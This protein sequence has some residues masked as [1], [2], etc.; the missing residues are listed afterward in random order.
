MTVP[1]LRYLAVTKSE[2]NRSNKRKITVSVKE[3]NG[4]PAREAEVNL[5]EV[6]ENEKLKT[7]AIGYTNREGE[8]SFNGLAKHKSYVLKINYRGI[9]TEKIISEEIESVVED[10]DEYEQYTQEEEE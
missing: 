7:L 4:R 2:D 10:F 6:R 9:K 5:Y 8:V 3:W 1:M